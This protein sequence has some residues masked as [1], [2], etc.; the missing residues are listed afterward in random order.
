MAGFDLGVL[1]VR[2]DGVTGT[3]GETFAVGRF[4]KEVL[5]R[6]FIGGV[7][8]AREGG[9]NYNRVVAADANLV[10]MD[11]LRVG[12]MLA[13]S[14]EPSADGDGW[15]RHA[16]AQWRDDFLQ[17]GFIVLDISSDFDPGIGFV[18]RRERMMGGSFSLR[19]R[20]SSERIRQL[21]ISPSLVYFHDDERDLQ[22]RRATVRLGVTLESGDVVRLD[23]KNRVEALERPFSIFSGVTLSAGR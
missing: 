14:F 5:G 8:T 19:P 7:V 17:A 22:T 11:H 3:P 21:E 13:R 18:M 23:L 4:R 10:F 6:S 15:V 16:A 2:T 1:S 20:P 9:G 12:A